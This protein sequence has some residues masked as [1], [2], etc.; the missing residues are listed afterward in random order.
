MANRH[1]FR[2]SVVVTGLA[3]AALS[4][5]GIGVS[6]QGG[7]VTLGSYQSDDVPKAA[8][9]AG[10]DY[11]EEQTGVHGHHHTTNHN[12]FQE[13]IYLLSPGHA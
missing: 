10:I 6:A 9:Q 5:S 2:R 13:A 12:D 4:F 8:L 7:T 3:A 1:L 11:C